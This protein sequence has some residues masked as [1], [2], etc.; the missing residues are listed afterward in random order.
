MKPKLD[1]NLG[2]RGLEILSRA[3][4]D[5]ATVTA[6][7]LQQAEDVVLIEE[8]RR[9][10][11]ALISLDMDFANPLHF[12]PSQYSGIAVLR[13]P[14]KPSREDLFTAMRTLAAALEKESLTGKLWIVELGRVRVF[15]EAD[16][17]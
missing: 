13:L 6:Q 8:C 15:Q 10:A 2:T 1:E 17:P 9:E 7:S 4:H 3:G 14:R 16:Q 12:K 5:V 11:Q